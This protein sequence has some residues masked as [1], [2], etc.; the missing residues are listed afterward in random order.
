MKNQKCTLKG[1]CSLAL[2]LFF[3]FFFHSFQQTPTQQNVIFVRYIYCILNVLMRNVP[4]SHHDTKGESSFF[5]FSDQA[6]V[7]WSITLWLC[8]QASIRPVGNPRQFSISGTPNLPWSVCAS[9]WSLSQ[10][11]Y[12]A[13]VVSPVWP[14]CP[15]RNGLSCYRPGV[16]SSCRFLRS[17]KSWAI[18]P[19][20]LWGEWCSF[21]DLQN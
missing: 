1:F 5:H 4:V 2:Y 21:L 16:S 14:P 13:S 20:A 10:F 17:S 7:H 6:V 12:I 19:H 11:V 9:C 8:C 15:Q 18:R 3:S